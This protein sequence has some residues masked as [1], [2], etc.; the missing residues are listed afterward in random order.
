MPIFTK[1]KLCFIHIPK[2]AGTSIFEHL[3]INEPVHTNLLHTYD[4][5]RS[6]KTGKTSQ[7]L[8]YLELHQEIKNLNEY[9]LFTVVRNPYTRIV[10]EYIWGQKR[11]KHI[12]NKFSTF[13]D[14]IHRS[15]RAPEKVRVTQFD[16]HLEPQISYIKECNKIN[17]FYYEQ[18]ENLNVWLKQ[19]YNLKGELPHL[20]MSEFK[21]GIKQ[22][23]SKTE[24][25]TRIQKFYSE[26][27][28]T[29]N[30]DLNVF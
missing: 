7:H 18:L 16:G 2:T 12:Y 24:T 27:F 22:L 30:Y 9:T 4:G 20:N 25:I 14:F 23:T 11:L 28:L 26:D 17:I 15:L 13:D 6:K 3:K 19:N 10:S 1:Q 21:V 8:T 29:F 5:I